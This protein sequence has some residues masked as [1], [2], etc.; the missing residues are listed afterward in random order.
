MALVT[1]ILVAGTVYLFRNRSDTNFATWAGLCLTVTGA[2]H[3]LCVRD[4]K[5]PDCQ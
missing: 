5:T 1:L 2:Y 4:D 3:W